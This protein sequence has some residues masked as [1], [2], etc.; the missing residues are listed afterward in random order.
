MQSGQA[1]LAQWIVRSC[2]SESFRIRGRDDLHM[3]FVAGQEDEPRLRS[4]RFDEAC[5]AS[6]ESLRM[7]R[8]RRS[9]RHGKAEL[10]GLRSLGVILVS[11]RF[12]KPMLRWMMRIQ[13][14]S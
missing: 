4:M 5:R 6:G 14:I 2:K 12:I 10:F 8:V 13:V 9:Q 11:P 7:E 1:F 3:W